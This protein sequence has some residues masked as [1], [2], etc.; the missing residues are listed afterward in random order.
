MGKKPADAGGLFGW[1]R[2]PDDWRAKSSRLYPLGVTALSPRPDSALRFGWDFVYFPAVARFGR[3]AVLGGVVVPLLC[4]GAGLAVPL[5]EDVLS[6]L[7]TALV[8]V[9]TG[10]GLAMAP[11]L[12]CAFLLRRPYWQPGVV[13]LLLLNLLVGVP[14]SYGA[15]ALAQRGPHAPAV[16]YVL[17]WLGLQGVFMALGSAAAGVIWL[18]AAWWIYRRRGVARVRM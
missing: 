16:A 9:V 15:Q 13:S 1:V 14:L 4:A 18:P 5:T 11:S 2:G 3:H 17:D 12:A 6:T 7:G 10:F 8:M